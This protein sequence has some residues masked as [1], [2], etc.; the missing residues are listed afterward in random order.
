MSD[1]WVSGAIARVDSLLATDASQIE[2][3]CR[4]RIWCRISLKPYRSL[5]PQCLPAISVSHCMPAEHR[6]SPT[7]IGT[8]S[9][10][11]E[12]RER[13]PLDMRA[14]TPN[15]VAGA[16]TFSIFTFFRGTNHAL[17][18]ATGGQSVAPFSVRALSHLAQV[19]SY[20]PFS[21]LKA[22]RTTVDSG[23]L[24]NGSDRCD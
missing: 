12:L 10:L 6:R 13:R 16:R 18:F 1:G 8:G 5:S 7:H 15:D 9:W 14:N 22:S 11:L 19:P 2:R 24:N 17:G 20:C 4:W 23:V 21:L 3:R